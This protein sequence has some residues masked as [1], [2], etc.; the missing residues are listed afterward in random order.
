[1]FP[2]HLIEFLLDPTFEFMR[3]MEENEGYSEQNYFNR[4]YRKLLN[5]YNN[6]ALTAMELS[7]RFHEDHN[8]KYYF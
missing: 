4:L 3:V 7:N 5:K 6:V 1:M 2:F 8:V